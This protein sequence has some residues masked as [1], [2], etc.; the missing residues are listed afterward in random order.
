MAH[1]VGMCF[2]HRLSG[3]GIIAI[4]KNATSMLKACLLPN[5]EWCIK[6]FHDYKH[7][8][9]FCIILRDPEERFLSALNMYLMTDRVMSDENFATKESQNEHFIPQSRFIHNL[10]AGAQVDYFYLKHGIVQDLNHHYGW[11]L[12]DLGVLYS[13]T[14][15]VDSAILW[16]M[17]KLYAEDYELISSVKFINHKENT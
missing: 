14:K 3:I 15:I 7:L 6:N 16:R 12:P 8:N 2:V 13:S 17:Q 4:P 10:P 1:E 11:D 9:R 5:P